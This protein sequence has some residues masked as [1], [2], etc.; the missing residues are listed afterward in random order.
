MLDIAS[1]ELRDIDDTQLRF[2]SASL[3]SYFGG[4]THLYGTVVVR[5]A[6]DDALDSLVLEVVQGGGAVATVIPK[7]LHH[8]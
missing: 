1:I 6:E 2:L 8:G 7:E 4:D 3:H 5:G